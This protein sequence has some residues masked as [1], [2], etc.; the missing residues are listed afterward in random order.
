MYQFKIKFLK[1]LGFPLEVADTRAIL[2]KSGFANPVALVVV[3]RQQ[4]LQLRSGCH[5]DLC[6]GQNLVIYSLTQLEGDS[7]AH[8]TSVLPF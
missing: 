4:N 8:C 5:S 1:T 7:V 6:W 3:L 2:P